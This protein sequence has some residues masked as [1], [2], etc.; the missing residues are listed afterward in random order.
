MLGMRFAQL[1]DAVCNVLF[2]QARHSYELRT[3]HLRHAAK[4]G[5]PACAQPARLGT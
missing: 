3:F 1:A 2:I 4:K 5:L